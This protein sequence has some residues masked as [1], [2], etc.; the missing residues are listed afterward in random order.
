MTRA[1]AELGAAID[2]ME[3]ATQKILQ[4]TE[5]ID[6]SARA[7]GATLK[8]D[9]ERGLAQDMQ[10]QAVAIYEACN[11]QDLAGQRIGKVIGMLGR[12]EAQ[13]AAIIERSGGPATLDQGAR[14]EKPNVVSVNGPP[15]DGE[16]GYIDQS[17]ID[18]MFN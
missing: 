13:L 7:L 4:A 16:S 14:L 1:A 2:T 10:E 3:K 8:G 9:Y 12:I 11:F 17:A 18:A 5:C 6:D 15:L